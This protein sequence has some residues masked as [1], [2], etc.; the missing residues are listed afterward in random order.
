MERTGTPRASM[1][2]H[3]NQVEREGATIWGH[4][5]RGLNKAAAI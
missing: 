1:G 3:R 2:S 4:N 5:A